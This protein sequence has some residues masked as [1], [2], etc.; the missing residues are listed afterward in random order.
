MMLRNLFVTILLCSI[1]GLASA[2]EP[3]IATSP[4][5]P[6]SAQMGASEASAYKSLDQDVQDLKKEVLDLNKEL[7][8]LEEDLLYPANTQ[9]A[10]FVSMD[11]GAFFGL[12]SVSLKL[13]NKEVANYLY[14]EKE[15]DALLKGG[16][17]RL[18]VGNLKLGEHELVAFFSGKGP[19]NQDY[20]RAASLKLQKGV[21]A[22]YVELK[23]SDRAVKQQPELIVKEWE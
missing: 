17:Q 8:V 6:A 11:V 5:E 23:V 10:V 22:K 12:T 19:Q 1:A 3:A 7:F 9:L 2:A 4:L 13:D 14:T 15:A 20:R 16:M 21:G 18:Y